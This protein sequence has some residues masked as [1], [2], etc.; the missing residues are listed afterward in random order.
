MKGEIMF[1]IFP[2]RLSHD[3]ARHDFVFTFWISLASPPEEA[4]PIQM[5][6][7]PPAGHTT[8]FS[9]GQTTVSP[10]S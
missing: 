4:P 6:D 9:S 5:P 8:A 10:A 2:T 3:F 1:L 7:L